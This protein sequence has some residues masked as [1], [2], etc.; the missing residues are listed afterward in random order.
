MRHKR[1]VSAW[2]TETPSCR[3]CR[4][5]LWM[6]G[7]ILSWVAS[8]VCDADKYIVTPTAL[9]FN[10]D[11]PYECQ[12]Y[13]ALIRPTCSLSLEE[14]SEFAGSILLHRGQDVCID[15]QSNFDAL[16]P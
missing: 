5:I 7:V 8:E 4:E 14:G 1:P 12:R 6:H 13:F 11:R 10:K 3:R 15:P 16:M 2:S 9:R